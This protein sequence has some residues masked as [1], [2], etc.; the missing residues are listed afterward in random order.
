MPEDLKTDHTPL[1]GLTP[2]GR[3]KV[4]QIADTAPAC[5][6]MSS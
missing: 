6:V 4:I 3:K 2:F 5:V 1:S